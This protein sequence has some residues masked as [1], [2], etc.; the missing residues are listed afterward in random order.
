MPGSS[1]SEQ[2]APKFGFTAAEATRIANAIAP[3]PA[4]GFWGAVATFNHVLDKGLQ[5]FHPVAILGSQIVGPYL[6]RMIGKE[7]LQM[8]HSQKMQRLLSTAL[9]GT[10]GVSASAII[11]STAWVAAK[12]WLHGNIKAQ[13]LAGIITRLNPGQ[14]KDIYFEDIIGHASVKKEFRKFILMAKELYNTRQGDRMAVVLE[15]PSGTGKTQM[16]KAFVNNLNR[17]LGGQSVAMLNV[18]CS[19]LNPDSVEHLSH[20]IN[21]VPEDVVVVFMDEMQSLG[22]QEK[23]GS[24]TKEGKT[25]DALLKVLDGIEGF[26]KGKVV[27]P[28]AATNYYHNLDSNLQT[29]LQTRYYMGKPNRDDLWQM[30]ELYRKRH[31]LEP[32]A[33]LKREKVLDALEGFCGR[34]VENTIKGLKRTLKIQRLEEGVHENPA[35][36]PKSDDS[37]LGWLFPRNASPPPKASEPESMRFTQE[38]L[39]QAIFNAATGNKQETLKAR[40]LFSA[41]APLPHEINPFETGGAAAPA[42]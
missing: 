19:R 13:D 15:G 27:I 36:P 3:L 11:G 14:F 31:N 18:N 37:L 21:T 6:N 25:L 20:L 1:S 33:A 38:Q 30:L 26:K 16:T 5:L 29:R 8:E 40:G 12:S 28:I 17:K 39:L 23:L 24:G 22:S 2:P 7:L 10:A 4:T 41:S 42:A 32:I 35:P 9:Y 34:E